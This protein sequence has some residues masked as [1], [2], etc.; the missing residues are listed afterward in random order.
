MIPFP[1]PVRLARNSTR[2]RLHDL[3]VYEAACSG[4]P[5]PEH[6]PATDRYL[7]DREVAARYGV[8]R[9]APWRWAR[10]S[11]ADAARATS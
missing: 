8:S 7:T 2:W 11:H 9:V 1:R 10:A 4:A 6:D 5:I 3:I